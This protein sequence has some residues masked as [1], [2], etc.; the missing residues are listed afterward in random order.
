VT[1]SEDLAFARRLTDIA[2]K[3]ALEHFR[4]GVRAE[5]KAD[6]TPVSAADL[7]VERCLRAL[8]AD[9]RPGDAIL[10]EELGVSGA[11]Q[12][13]WLIDPIDGTAQFVSGKAEWGTHVALQHDGELVLGVISRPLLRRTW[14]ASRGNGAYRGGAGAT[15]CV[16]LHV[17]S[18][19]NLRQSR[20]T[21]WT[22]EQSANVELLKGAALWVEPNL[23]ALLRLA[24]GELEA[25]VDPYGKAW[26]HAP[27][28]VLVEEAG[29]RFSDW[30]GGHRVD[31]GEGRFTNGAVH[32][33]LEELLG[34]GV[35]QGALAPT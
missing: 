14:W 35:A 10:G 20:V 9:E 8:L 12:R 6:G 17:S 22:D 25:V 21:V 18:T 5:L 3:I 32:A 28:V 13:V 34:V 7:E 26:D 24:E 29:G 16:K 19:A 30:R 31:H 11:S 27:A 1:L 33:Q 23:D 4:S 15:D 2:G